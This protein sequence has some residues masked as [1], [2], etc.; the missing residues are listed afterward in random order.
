MCS[1]ESRWWTKSKKQLILCV[2]HHCQNPIES[3]IYVVFRRPIILYF[4]EHFQ[5]VLKCLSSEYL[6]WYSCLSRSWIYI[7][8]FYRWHRDLFRLYTEITT[9]SIS[10]VL[11]F[12]FLYTPAT[13][14]RQYITS[15]SSISLTLKYI[16]YGGRGGGWNQ[17]EHQLSLISSYLSISFLY[18]GRGTFINW[19]VDLC[20][21]ASG[22]IVPHTRNFIWSMKIK[23]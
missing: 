12:Y 3:T 17:A 16:T 5:V 15:S 8:I 9:K 10:L 20:C 13:N 21:I 2:I 7:V 1:L 18:C 22:I 14:L 23:I 6:I 4:S 11:L 19:P